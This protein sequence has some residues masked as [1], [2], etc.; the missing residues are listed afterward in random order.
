MTGIV[1]VETGDQIRLA[2]LGR[3]RKA[4]A[5]AKSA[6]GRNGHCFVRHGGIL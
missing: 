4:E 5:L 6:P 1:R 2:G 3:D